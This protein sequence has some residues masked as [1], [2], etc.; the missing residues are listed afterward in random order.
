MVRDEGAANIKIGKVQLD[1]KRR[2]WV[3]Q[4][5]IHEAIVWLASERGLQKYSDEVWLLLEGEAWCILGR[6]ER[7]EWNEDIV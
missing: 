6:G 3:L 2:V 5:A 7:R 4:R 1:T